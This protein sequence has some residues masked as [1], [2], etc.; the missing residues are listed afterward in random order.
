MARIYTVITSFK[1][2]LVS[3]INKA[4]LKANSTDHNLLLGDKEALKQMEVLTWGFQYLILPNTIRNCFRN[5]S[6]WQKIFQSK[7]YQHSSLY[8][9]KNWGNHGKIRYP[10]LASNRRPYWNILKDCL[11]PCFPATYCGQPFVGCPTIKYMPSGINQKLGLCGRGFLKRWEGIPPWR[12]LEGTARL[13]CLPG[14]LRGGKRQVSF[15]GGKGDIWGM[16][17]NFWF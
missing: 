7:G 8:W 3:V 1:D 16:L 9:P 14:L 4:K 10:K 15:K 17:I 2:Y 12:S 6:M 5:V 11:L 13:S